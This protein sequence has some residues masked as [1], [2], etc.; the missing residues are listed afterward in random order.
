M[1]TRD[2]KLGSNRTSSVGVLFVA[3]IAA[4]IDLAGAEDRVR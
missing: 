3:P 4:T 2:P 1:A